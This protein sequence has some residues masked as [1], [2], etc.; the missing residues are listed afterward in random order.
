MY[1]SK[2]NQILAQSQKFYIS[3]VDPESDLDL[4]CVEDDGE[5]DNFTL[6]QSTP[7]KEQGIKQFESSI[8]RRNFVHKNLRNKKM[9]SYLSWY[10]NK[11]GPCGLELIWHC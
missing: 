2:A 11:K 8:F 3:Y 9:I 1:I 5:L 7:E 4:V 6:V 10:N